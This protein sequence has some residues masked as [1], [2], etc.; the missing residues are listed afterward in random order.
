MVALTDSHSH[1]R[2]GHRA[3]DYAPRPLQFLCWTRVRALL[4]LT[5]GLRSLYSNGMSATTVKLESQLLRE[6]AK[7]KSPSQTLASYVR[8]A[9][10]TDLRRR[11]LR[12]AAEAYQKFLGQR[13]TERQDLG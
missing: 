11:R 1:F 12:A 4:T 2:C 9:V 13:K 10:E 3:G 6:I 7:V 5:K 8:E